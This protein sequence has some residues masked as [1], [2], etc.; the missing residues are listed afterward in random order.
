MNVQTPLLSPEPPASF[1]GPPPP[2]PY[3]SASPPAVPCW[4]PSPPLPPNPLSTPLPPPPPPPATARRFESPYGEMRMSDAPPPPPPWWSPCAVPPAPPPFHPA[5]PTTCPSVPSPPTLTWS[6]VPSVTGMVAVTDPPSPPFP[7]GP[8]PAP[9]AAPVTTTWIARVPDG[10]AQVCDAPVEA[11]VWLVQLGDGSGATARAG[12]SPPARRVTVSTEVATT[13]KA[14]A[15]VSFRNRPTSARPFVRRPQPGRSSQRELRRAPR[16][17]RSR[18]ST[19]ASNSSRLSHASAGGMP[20]MS[21]WK[22]SVPKSPSSFAS[23]TH[24]SGVTTL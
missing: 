9:P 17:G 8:P 16:Q 15:P 13:V 2:H 12:V 3:G 1:P 23:S 24:S 11:K 7:P 6:A 18:G 20:P 5:V 22:R 21:G 10:I 14:S 4:P 19:L